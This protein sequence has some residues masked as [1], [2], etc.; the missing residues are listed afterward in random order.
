MA[1]VILKSTR[2]DGVGKGVARRLREAGN[3]PAIYYGRGEEPVA[4]TVQV[5]ELE[6]LLHGS[7]G[8]NVIV[9]LKVEGAAAA[10]RKA[11][12]REIQRHPVRGNI[13]HVDLQHISL[14][15]RITV[16]V[17]VVLVGVPTGVK[18]GGGILEHL[19][20]EVEV[21]CLPTDIPE[22][23]TVDVSNLNIG[24]SVHVSDLVIG[25]VVLRTEA[26]R[27]VATVVPPTVLE[28]VKP[29][30]AV[31]AE[32]ELVKKEKGSDDEGEKKS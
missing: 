2:R 23:L 21:E 17:P 11:I 22:K 18:D 3:V 6:T 1:I 5:K 29:A 27:T 28:E 25:N 10:D 9:D 32:P 13:L 26:A 30:E 16:E 14:S 4:L 15:E 8:S 7:A 20:R 12:L 24:E 19:L 31:Q